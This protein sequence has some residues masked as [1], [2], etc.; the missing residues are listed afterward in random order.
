MDF[1]VHR[2][3]F[4]SRGAPPLGWQHTVEFVVTVTMLVAHAPLCLPVY[5]GCC[6]FIRREERTFVMFI[7][8]QIVAGVLTTAASIF[9]WYVS[10]E[11]VAILS[12]GFGLYSLLVGTVVA[13]KKASIEHHEYGARGAG[14]L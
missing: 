9:F 13:A 6:W 12:S 2:T 8:V 3:G 11:A 5:C 1:L 4:G 10:G 14:A 7:V